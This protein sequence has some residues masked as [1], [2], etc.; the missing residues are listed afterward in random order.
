M[1][2]ARPSPGTEPS[3]RNPKYARQL[4][5]CLAVV[6]FLVAFFARII[7]GPRTIDDSFITYRYTRNILAG[8]GFVYNPGER[9]LGTT[10]PLYTILLVILGFFTG[11]TQA[12]F[13]VLSMLVN[14]MCDGLTCLLLLRLGRKLDSPLAGIGCALVWAVA[15]YSVTFAIGGLETSLYVL[16][17]TG[18]VSAYADRR[19]PLAAFLGGLSLLTRPDALILLGPMALDRAITLFTSRSETSLARRVRSAAGEVIIFLA[20]VL[21]WIIFSVA[22]FGSPLPHSIAAKSLAYRLPGD[23]ALIRLLQHYATPFL[24]NLTFG[25]PAIGV[26][27]VLYLFLYLVGARHAFRAQNHLWFWLAYP[28]LYFITFAVANPLIFRWYLT[29]PLPAYFMV[30]LVGVEHILGQVV[31]ALRIRDMPVVRSSLI[32]ILVIFVPL[33]LTLHGWTLHPDHGPDYP[34]PDMA[35]IQLELLYRQAADSLAPELSSS[36]SPPS[37]AAGDVGVL[38]FYT[39]ARILDTVGLNSSVSTRYYPLDPAFYVINYAI[40]PNLILDQ[41]PDYIVIL[42]VYG[43][44]GLLLDPRFQA[45]Y[46]LRQKIPTD[47]YGSDGMLIYVRK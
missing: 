25:I 4:Y 23:A 36:S 41:L 18:V 47:M 40:P 16:L 24:E 38:G 28:W 5:I 7:P 37:L 44:A 34:A 6:I 39:G 35:Y 14:A 19:Y 15:P 9:V 21:P 22:Y 43:R 12:P 29:P 3:P 46:Q 32:S 45:A 1:P 30:I 27:A 2:M 20:P 42:E 13:P 8:N 26:G 31:S 33:G 17:L 11:G 10:T